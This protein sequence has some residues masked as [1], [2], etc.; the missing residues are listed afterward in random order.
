MKTKKTVAAIL[1]V[2]MTFTF[3]ACIDDNNSSSSKAEQTTSETTVTTTT[4]PDSTDSVS[5]TT[6]VTTSATSQT[7]QSDV[8]T[9]SDITAKK[10]EVTTKNKNVNDTNGVAARLKAN[11]TSDFEYV[12]NADGITLTKYIGTSVDVVIPKKINGKP[13]TAIGYYIN[14]REGR[15][16]CFK[17][18]FVKSVVIPNSVKVIEDF[19]F[20]NCN[21]ITKIILP[22]GLK[23]I[24]RYS[25]NG[26][27]NL[28]IVTMPNSVTSIGEHA[29]AGCASLTSVKISDSVTSLE[30]STFYG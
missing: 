3:T 4:L 14:S 9:S 24:G 28:S 15:E 23:S 18:P 20:D 6:S 29:F 13:V 16:G 8:T 11:S 10:V 7:T 30:D 17:D 25:F 5:S 2:L 26:C 22:Y 12:E 1:A 27:A 19:A 21:S